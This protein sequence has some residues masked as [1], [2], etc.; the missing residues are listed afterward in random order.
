MLLPPHA[1]ETY[2]LRL[3]LLG[4]T[5]LLASAW[6]YR[7]RRLPLGAP[8]LLAALPV[9]ALFFYAPLLFNCIGAAREPDIITIVLVEFVLTWLA[10]YK[11]RRGGAQLCRLPLLSDFGQPRSAQD[12][13]TVPTFIL[14][15]LPHRR[16]HGRAGVDRWHGHGTCCSFA[17]CC[18]RPSRRWRQASGASLQGWV[19]WPC[20][21]AP[22]PAASNKHTE[23]R[24]RRLTR[25]VPMLLRVGTLVASYSARHARPATSPGAIP[26][27]QQAAL[28]PAPATLP[29]PCRAVAA[30]ASMPAAQ[31]R[32]RAHLLPRPPCWRLA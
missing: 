1:P 6:L 9:V 18:W 20:F 8:R 30:R 3:A 10:S 25:S 23:L 7:C 26:A 5:C 2:L 17:P 16:W 13:C 14:L 27:V 4:P 19:G 12:P 21:L 29:R 31:A 24:R 22:G 15:L 28:P 11:V 32:W